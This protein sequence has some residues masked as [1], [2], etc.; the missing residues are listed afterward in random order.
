MDTKQ[1][2]MSIEELIDYCKS[3][4]VDRKLID[5]VVKFSLDARLKEKEAQQEETPYANPLENSYTVYISLD[6]LTLLQEVI[7]NLPLIV[8]RDKNLSIG[9]EK[10]IKMGNEAAEKKSELPAVVKYDKNDPK[11]QKLVELIY[12]NIKRRF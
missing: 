1:K 4:F 6:R 5:M 3:M 8:S 11:L 9:M 12:I 7:E 10:T 2:H